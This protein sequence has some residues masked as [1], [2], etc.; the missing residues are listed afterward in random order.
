MHWHAENTLHDHIAEAKR[1]Y[2]HVDGFEDIL[3][4][5]PPS[6]DGVKPLCRKIR[7][8]LFPLLKDGALFTRTPANPEKLYEPIIEAFD[9]AIPDI[10]AREGSG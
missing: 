8:I 3:D 2:M 5:F 4:E 7:V 1:G 10:A 6:F 9:D